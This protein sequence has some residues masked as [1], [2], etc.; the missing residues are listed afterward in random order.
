MSSIDF[1]IYD[2]DQLEFMKEECILVNSQDEV[3][4]HASKIDCHLL[5]NPD[6]KGLLHRAFSVFLFNNKKEL[7][8]QQ[9][10][11][12]KVTFPLF[13]ANTCCSHPLFCENELIEGHKL[14]IK[15]AAKRKLNHELGIPLEE[16]HIDDMKYLSKIEY[17]ANYNTQWG[18]NE[19][20]NIIVMKPKNDVH[21]YIN[22]NEVN[23]IHWFTKENLLSFIEEAPSNN[24]HVSPW[25][26]L[27][28]KQYIEDIFSIAESFDSFK[29]SF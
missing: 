16:I 11:S 23:N 2:K 9:R 6:D 20:D 15:N 3:L 27:I 5:K 24:I 12:E 7:L 18:E 1:S 21:I 17:S 4:G 13:W 25:L 22:E 8:L 10:S 19:V 14:G 28:C 26:I 29:E